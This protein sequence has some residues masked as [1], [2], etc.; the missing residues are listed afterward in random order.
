[1]IDIKKEGRLFNGHNRPN[2]VK[3]FR[4]KFGDFLWYLMNN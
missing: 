3:R 4:E 2:E 1:M